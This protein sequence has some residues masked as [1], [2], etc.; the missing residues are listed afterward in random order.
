MDSDERI[1]TDA[2]GSR[3]LSLGLSVKTVE[4]FGFRADGAGS[5]CSPE[6]AAPGGESPGLRE[7]EGATWR[8]G[9]VL[10]SGAFGNVCRGLEVKSG[11]LIAV[12]TLALPVEITPPPSATGC[13]LA[14]PPPWMR[15][16]SGDEPVAEAEAS[17][18]N[19][20][21][22]LMREARILE[23]LE[24]PHVIRQLGTQLSGD[25]R[26]LFILMELAAGGSLRSVVKEFGPLSEGVCARMM[27]QALQ[28]LAYLHE[29][30]VVHRD[31]KPA[32]LLLMSDGVVKLGDFG[33]ARRLNAV[34]TV[35]RDELTESLRRMTGTVPYM[36][37]RVIREEGSG[38]ADDLWALGGC[39]LFVLTGQ[40]PWQEFWE[41]KVVDQTMSLALAFHIAK[42]GDRGPHLPASGLSAGA[43]AFIRKCFEASC[44]QDVLCDKWLETE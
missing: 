5:P 27:R 43:T 37:P 25:G 17:V 38:P 36:S 33:A 32:N 19:P 14:S 23:D 21:D 31:I 13:L 12:K 34:S 16:W 18:A 40:D 35:S 30:G 20:I 11:R 42:H 8:L 29:Q 2:T 9:L 6:L 24:H 41:G 26:T 1:G 7:P 44:V 10:A 28:G 22:L 15:A 4:G 39:C 3:A